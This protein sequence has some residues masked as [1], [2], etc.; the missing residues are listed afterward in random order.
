GAVLPDSRRGGVPRLGHA[1]RSSHLRVL[2]ILLPQMAG[3]SLPARGRSPRRRRGGPRA[4]RPLSG[5]AAGRSRTQAKG[6]MKLSLV[7]P[8]Y[9]EAANLPLLI[10]R[11]A[12]VVTRPDVEVI[13]VD[14]GSK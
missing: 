7:I 13:L 12:E 11:L 8:C 5:A 14:N 6:R 2:A 4:S 10:G 9:N 1:Q 3:A